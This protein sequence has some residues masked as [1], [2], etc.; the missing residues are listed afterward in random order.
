MRG[1]K[2]GSLLGAAILLG[3]FGVGTAHAA[4]PA[5]AADDAATQAMT[6]QAT[7]DRSKAI[8]KDLCDTATASAAA[9]AADPNN[10][11]KQAQAASDAAACATAQTNADNEGISL[12]N[13]NGGT[14]TAGTLDPALPA[15]V[16]NTANNAVKSD[17]IS[18]LSNSRGLPSFSTTGIPGMN[19]NDAGATFMHFEKL[20]Y[21]FLL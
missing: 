12:S 14:A 9:A 19:G 21:D 18:W 3:T 20:G 1:R 5:T 10:V 17:N 4:P 11:A 7:V 16:H 8:A 13:V 15:D 2:V 6:T